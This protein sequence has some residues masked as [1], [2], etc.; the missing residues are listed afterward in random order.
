MVG[1]PPKDRCPRGSVP[2][3]PRL[4]PTE[5]RVGPGQVRWPS[6]T[7]NYCTFFRSPVQEPP[8]CQLSDWLN[9]ST[10]RHC[11]SVTGTTESLDNR[12]RSQ[13]WSS[14]SFLIRLKET[15]CR[16][17]RTASTSTTTDLGSVSLGSAVGL[18]VT[19][20]SPTTA[21]CLP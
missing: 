1:G 11:T 13:S 8:L 3:F 12:T 21:F 7:L 4:G 16:N 18:A 9:S 14:G 17:C 20:I 10:R 5:R 6:M 15:G 2:H 19:R